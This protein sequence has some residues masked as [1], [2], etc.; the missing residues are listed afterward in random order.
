MGIDGLKLDA[1]LEDRHTLI[2]ITALGHT[3]VLDETTKEKNIDR[4]AEK[5]EASFD[6]EV[7]AK[8]AVNPATKWGK[9]TTPLG[10]GKIQDVRTWVW[11]MAEAHNVNAENIPC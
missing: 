8:F 4:D 11:S 3:L 7:I 6:G 1:L 5:W 10:R 9:V 2:K